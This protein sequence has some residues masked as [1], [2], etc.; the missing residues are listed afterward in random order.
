MM[1][2]QQAGMRRF[3]LNAPDSATSFAALLAP[4]FEQH[5]HDP[6]LGATPCQHRGF[7]QHCA[8]RPFRGQM[9]CPIATAAR[10]RARLCRRSLLDE[11][12]RQLVAAAQVA[13][14]GPPV[15]K[16]IA[17]PGALLPQRYRPPA[18]FRA[19]LNNVSE[20]DDESVQT[21]TAA[22]QASL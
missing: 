5:I 14:V 10:A 1:R 2:K 22:E 4:R 11:A 13:P 3:K 12:Q 6:V 20:L 17:P 19:D 21:R 8:L 9:P 16:H 15:S 18:T 7:R